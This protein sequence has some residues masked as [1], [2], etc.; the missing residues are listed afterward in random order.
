MLLLK[1]RQFVLD[2]LN[3]GL[4][5]NYML[6]K[7]HVVIYRESGFVLT[8][9]LIFIVYILQNTSIMLLSLRPNVLF[10]LLLFLLVCLILVSFGTLLINFFIVV[11]LML[12]QT[13]FILQIWPTLLPAF[14]HLRFTNFV[15]I[16]SR[17][18]TPFLL[19]YC[20]FIFLLVLISFVRQLLLKSLNLLVS[21]LILT[22]ILILFLLLCSKNVLLLFFP[23]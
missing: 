10:L 23:P 11:L 21:L 16:F 2:H 3:P 22:V 18:Q 9:L 17:I 19:M 7:F 1:Q 14:S 8:L 20:A 15:L 12:Y 4:L 5:L 6:S 13:L